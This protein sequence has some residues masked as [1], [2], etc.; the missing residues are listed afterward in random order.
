MDQAQTAL[1]AEALRLRDAVSRR[2]HDVYHV[3]IPRLAECKDVSEYETELHETLQRIASLV[4]QMADDVDDA[5]SAAER[6]AL[7]TLVDT[8]RN[9]LMRVRQASRRALLAAHRATVSRREDSARSALLSHA[10]RQ[11]SGVRAAPLD[12]ASAT[13]EQVTGALQRTVKLMS[14]ELEK[15]GYS[16]Q[17]LAESSETIAQVSNKYASFNDL[18]RDSVSMIRQMELAELVDLG[19][20]GASITF[21]LACVLYILYARIF[22][23]GIHALSLTWHASSSIG[24]GALG[25]FSALQHREPRHVSREHDPIEEAIRFASSEEAVPRRHRKHAQKA[26]GKPWVD[27]VE[28][29]ASPTPPRQSENPGSF[30]ENSASPLTADLPDSAHTDSLLAET[31]PVFLSPT[32]KAVTASANTM[33]ASLPT[34]KILTKSQSD[35][36]SALADKRFTDKSATLSVSS[37]EVVSASVSA[38]SESVSTD[39]SLTAESAAS[40]VPSED[41]SSP[42]TGAPPEPIPTDSIVPEKSATIS[43][44]KEDAVSASTSA[45]SEPVL[46]QEVLAAKSTTLLVPEED[47]SS[48]STSTGP[49]S[50]STDQEVSEST[51]AGQKSPDFDSTSTTPE[52]FTSETPARIATS[53]A[54]DFSGNSDYAASIDRVPSSSSDSSLH[55]EPTSLDATET[56]SP[57]PPLFDL[58]S[59]SERRRRP[60]DEL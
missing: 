35:A 28:L 9:E 14:S 19:I 10:A 57:T 1:P 48:A 27:V 23:R 8:N 18:L 33:P 36:F 30:S 15:S 53:T 40:L 50:V 49:E 22:S 51:A 4:Q 17:L 5:E 59:S 47:S 58:Q 31:S 52:P 41:A 56:S 11:N 39:D 43:A 42:S 29:T 26:A 38:I 2:L 55:S 20:L 32:E 25:L 44:R 37:E 7:K 12:R 3:Q 6:A 13:S 16:T 45:L 60:W 21:F 24:S 34:G 46:T 54:L